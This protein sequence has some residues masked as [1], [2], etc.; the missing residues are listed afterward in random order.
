MEALCCACYYH[1]DVEEDDKEIVCENC[2]VALMVYEDG[3][4]EVMSEGEV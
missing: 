3:S 2:G 4:T 1:N